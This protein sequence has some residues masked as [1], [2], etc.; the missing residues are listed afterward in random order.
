MMNRSLKSG[1]FA[2]FAWLIF[3]VTSLGLLAGCVQS[4][5]V[6]A[7]PTPQLSQ[8]YEITAADSG[9]TF[10]YP[11]TTRF[12]VLLNPQD[13]PV[14]QLTCQ[15]EGILGRISNVPEVQ[16]PLQAFRFEAVQPGSCTLQAGDFQV[17]INVVQQP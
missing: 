16:P 15:P 10:T 1:S 6:V 2:L 17:T 13:Y 7:T 9:Q 3:L 14:D 4:T 12:T 5:P 8:S 11:L